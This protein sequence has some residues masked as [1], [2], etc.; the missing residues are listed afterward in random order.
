MDNV[1][2]PELVER[3]YGLRA[4]RL[5]Y[6]D[7][8]GLVSPSGLT[9]KKK[10]RVYTFQDIISLKVVK[11]LVDGGLSIQ[12]I[13]KLLKGL[14]RLM[15][16]LQR[17]LL[18]LRI[19]CDGKRIF[20]NSKGVCLEP[21]GQLLFD[22][23]L[24]ELE[25]ELLVPPVDSSSPE[26]AEYW[27]EK[28]LNLDMDPK[29][30]QEAMAAYRKAIELDPRMAEAHTNLGNLYYMQKKPEKAKEFYLKAIKLDS[31]HKEAL[32]NLANI[33]M[34]ELKFKE[35]AA[36]YKRAIELDS[37]FVDAY[38]NLALCLENLDKGDEARRHWQVY[39]KSDH[40]SEWSRIAKEH[41]EDGRDDI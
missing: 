36:L 2:P 28:G 31:K 24:S 34:E 39:L 10:R 16:N 38:F 17:P 12:R 41:L 35:A 4:G 29:T 1:F 40:S 33:L 9:E 14:K 11:S 32:F 8:I 20:L 21:T 22:F 37:E 25:K 13:R 30:H 15:P 6:W 26:S 27:F 3:L 5:R 7:M 18:E 19:Q 23:S